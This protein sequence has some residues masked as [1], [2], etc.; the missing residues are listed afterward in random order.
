VTLEALGKLD[1]ETAVIVTIEGSA[2]DLSFS[3]VI[4][5]RFT[6]MT[7]FIYASFGNSG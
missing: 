5:L 1:K 2:Q 4:L 6:L 3:A 7:G